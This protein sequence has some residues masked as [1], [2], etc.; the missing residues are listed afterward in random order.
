MIESS[1]QPGKQLSRQFEA[2][3]IGGGVIGC[4]IAWRLRQAGMS[5]VVVER[6]EIGREASHAAGGMLAPL[7][8]ADEADD[9]FRLAVASRL[10]YA[11]FARE[12]QAA[13]G[14]D[15]E[16]RSEGTLYLVLT[17]EDEEELDRRWRWQ[18]A[19]GLN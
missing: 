17:D 15:I 16:Y 3:V 10:M 13:S 19:A 1:E 18:Q 2:V 9:F 5:V 14:I 8:E 12:L 11:D 6:G 7:A 4:S